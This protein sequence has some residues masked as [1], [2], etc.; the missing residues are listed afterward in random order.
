MVLL[1]AACGEGT[2]KKPIQT[3]SPTVKDI[4]VP[5]F[6]KDS[7]YAY[8]KKQVDFGPREPNSAA[9]KA[10]GD[11]MVA[12]LKSFG[13]TVT[14]QKDRVPAHDGNVLNM[15]NIIASFRPDRAN[16]I[17]LSAHWDTR[18]RADQDSDINRKN[19][20]ILG[21]ND[22]ASGVGILIEIARIMQETPAPIGVDLILWDIEDYGVPEAQGSYA[23]GSQYW[24]KTKH[25]ASYQALY[26]INLDMVGA[27]NA[28]F[29][30]EGYSMA[31]APN[32]VQKVWAAAAKLGYSN[33]FVQRRG[34]RI[35]DDHVYVNQIA[36]IPTIDIIHLPPRGGFF[37]HWHTHGDDLSV[38]DPKTLQAV[39]QT[40]LEVIYHE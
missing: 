30:K 16:R 8:V 40:L 21:A 12:K 4:L 3:N 33:Y 15:R 20:P 11:W 2:D 29:P 13:A 28:Q 24:S 9:H 10:C 17:F 31:F 6:D 37:R 1:F 32:V 19:D 23:L 27:E 38:I 5:F 25:K 22:G 14:E 26:G 36:Q 39:G 34:E 7:A 18:P 35:T